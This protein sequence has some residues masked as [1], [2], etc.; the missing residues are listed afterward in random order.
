M[1]SLLKSS[2][3]NP[4]SPPLSWYALNAGPPSD[5]T[6]LIATTPSPLIERIS[7]YLR[8]SLERNRFNASSHDIHLDSTN[9]SGHIKVPSQVSLIDKL[10]FKQQK[11]I[12]VLDTHRK[13][14]SLTRKFI[15]NHHMVVTSLVKH[16]LPP[17]LSAIPKHLEFT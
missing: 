8:Y 12:W 7:Y 11:T 13:N 1:T 14:D 16:I 5:S 2:D 6:S 9:N 17:P 15:K 4:D 3:L 10:I